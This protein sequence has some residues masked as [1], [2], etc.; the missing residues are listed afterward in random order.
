MLVS[1]VTCSLKVFLRFFYFY[2][3]NGG[4]DLGFV[5]FCGSV[6]GWGSEVDRQACANL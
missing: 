4:R 6:Y 3:R 1:V 2:L 5:S